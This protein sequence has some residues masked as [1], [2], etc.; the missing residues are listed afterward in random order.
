MGVGVE[1]LDFVGPGTGY[2]CEVCRV[3]RVGV[4]NDIGGFVAGL[5]GADDVSGG[6]VDDAD[7][8]GDVIDDPDF[9]VVAEA[10]RYGIVAD[11]DGGG[12]CEGAGAAVDG[13][14]FDAGVGRVDGGEGG[15]VRAEVEGIDVGGLEVDEGSWV[16]GD[17]ADGAARAAIGWK[18]AAAVREGR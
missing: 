10:D 16:G 13:E 1:D 12:G 18:A 6:N 9:V 2:R 4:E 7:G 5:D 3:A 17:G 14:N 11:G 8:I 15:S